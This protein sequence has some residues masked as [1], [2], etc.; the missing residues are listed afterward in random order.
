[1]EQQL[2]TV[3]YDHSALRKLQTQLMG[4]RGGLARVVPAA[5]NRTLA[6]TRTRMKREVANQARL[7][8]GRADRL[9]K[10]D[11]ASAGKWYGETEML[12]RRV[13]VGPFLAGASRSTTA[14][15]P[16]GITRSYPRHFRA[17]MP[18]GHQGLFV[19][20]RVA[21]PG[22]A[23]RRERRERVLSAQRRELMPALVR[24]RLWWT[25][26]PIYEQRERLGTVMRLDF[27]PK[28]QMQGSLRLQQEINSK[29][30]WLRAKS[31]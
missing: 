9:L 21:R 13:P 28:L 5:I 12:G 1:M 11:R 16:S 20:A 22:K 4:I 8:S 6:W 15:F 7:K 18:T 26:L 17:A 3:R 19:R 10:T 30:Q 31:G 14:M 25:E 24:R 23:V 27:L 2:L 29:I